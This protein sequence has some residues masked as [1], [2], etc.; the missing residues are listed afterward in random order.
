M[1]STSPGSFLLRTDLNPPRL[2]MLFTVAVMGSSSQSPLSGSPTQ[3]KSTRGDTRARFLLDYK[4][5]LLLRTMGSL[6]IHL[7]ES[8]SA[9]HL[10]ALGTDSA[11]LLRPFPQK[12]TRDDTRASPS[13]EVEARDPH[14]SNDHFYSRY[15]SHQHIVHQSSTLFHSFSSAL[16]LDTGTLPCRFRHAETLNLPESS[17]T[18]TSSNK[19]HF[20]PR[21]EF[22]PDAHF[23]RTRLPTNS[24]SG[25]VRG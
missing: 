23:R 21:K 7:W 4:F 2:Q 25:V 9:A 10:L 13:P 3:E 5:S 11:L 1:T 8:Y 15:R 17:F 20:S 12:S 19:T 22:K 18:F 24:L 16:S 6:P 14:S